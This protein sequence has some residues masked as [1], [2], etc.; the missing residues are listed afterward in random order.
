MFIHRAGDIGSYKNRFYVIFANLADEKINTYM[1]KIVAKLLSTYR[2]KVDG[3][4]LAVFRVLF[5]FITLLEIF[6][7]FYF[8]N[9]IFDRIPFIDKGEINL[10]IPFIVWIFSTIAV[11]FGFYT[12]VFAVFNYFLSVFLLGTLN[13]FHYHA[14]YSIIFV[15]F[16]FMFLPVSNRLSVDSVIRQIR[17]SSL[18]KTVHHFDNRVS[19]LYYF[20]IP[21]FGL[22]LVYFDSVL[23]KLGSDTWLAG[24]GVWHSS[25]ILK[26]ATPFSIYPLLNYEFLV[27]ALSWITVVFEFL[28]IFLFYFKTFRVPLIIIGCGL[29]LGIAIQFPIPVFGLLMMTLYILMIPFSYWRAISRFF[30]AKRYKMKLFLDM[31]FRHNVM[32]AAFVNSLDVFSNIEIVDS[33]GEDDLNKSIYCIDR[34]ALKYYNSEAII[35]VIGGLGYLI[36]FSLLLKLP[37]I[38]FIFEK[39]YQVL[40]SVVNKKL[41]EESQTKEG[42]ILSDKLDITYFKFTSLM[43]FSLILVLMQL[44]HIYN[45]SLLMDFRKKIGIYNTPPEKIINSVRSAYSTIARATLGVTTHAVFVGGRSKAPKKPTFIVAITCI[46]QEGDRVNIPTFDKLGHPSYYTFGVNWC[47][48]FNILSSRNGDEGVLKYV[49]RFSAFGAGKNNINLNNSLFEVKVKLI[50]SPSKWEKDFLKKQIEQKWI[51]LGT[52][53]WKDNK[54]QSNLDFSKL[55]AS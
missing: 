27:K 41:V 17:L 37:G 19:Q 11:I 10:T 54:F 30:K 13:G 46:S 5:S 48:M 39:L 25:S 52:V 55:S 40:S 50:T 8:R 14:H 22:G 43:L 21:F 45:S 35:K 23:Y 12:R 36:P 33:R 3:T 42:R 18:G 7:L 20:F 4:G 29:H 16:L 38:K 34:K 31:R 51:D 44:G 49:E 9:L 26:M 2:R 47:Y 53:T 1:K 32:I 28:F 24:L 15:N 6:H